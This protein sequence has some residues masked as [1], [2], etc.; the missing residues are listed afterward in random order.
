MQKDITYEHQVAFPAESR[1]N[2][3]APL[4]SCLL[5]SL[6]S[7]VPSPSFTLGPGPR[8]PT[9]CPP[10]PTGCAQDE[11]Y[12]IIIDGLPIGSDLSSRSP[13]GV[14][15]SMYYFMEILNVNT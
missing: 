12:I 3:L 9:P 15:G 8:G 4:V 2:A 10:S 7:A 11:T 6:S 1:I 13:Q 5:A 14:T